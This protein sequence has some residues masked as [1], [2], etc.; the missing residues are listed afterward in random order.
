MLLPECYRYPYLRRVNDCFVVVVVA[1]NDD[2]FG[3]GGAFDCSWREAGE[4]G[5]SNPMAPVLLPVSFEFA[6]A[7]SF[8][9]EFGV[10]AE[11]HL[12]AAVL[13]EEATFA[14]AKVIDW[15]RKHEETVVVV[16]FV[17]SERANGRAVAL[18]DE[19]WRGRF[20]EGQAF[21][22]GLGDFSVE[23]AKISPRN[24]SFSPYCGA[25]FVFSAIVTL[26]S[27]PKLIRT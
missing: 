3:G 18:L 8:A 7:Q 5:D 17:R 16:G 11:E 13:A 22:P 10:D 4:S 1:E 12:L 23:R 26:L 25:M 2:G 20:W 24:A 9:C 15:R 6:P 19:R 27:F 21:E 14:S